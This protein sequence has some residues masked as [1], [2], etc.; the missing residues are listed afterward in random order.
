VTVEYI[1]AVAV[2][3]IMFAGLV[4]LRPH[5][6]AGKTPVDAIPPIV[7]LLGRP[8]ENLAPRPARRP[9]PRSRPAQRPRPRPHAEEPA[10]VLLPEWWRTR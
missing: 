8:I 9:G 3:G 10:T 5:H 2:V 1:A 7:R 6:V 4:A